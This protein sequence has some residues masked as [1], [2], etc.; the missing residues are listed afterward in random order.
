[1]TN[2]AQHIASKTA[3]E[4]KVQLKGAFQGNY[5]V[6]VLCCDNGKSETLIFTD[7]QDPFY[8]KNNDILELIK[9]TLSKPNND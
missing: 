3:Q 9:E 7:S 1:M 4:F 5:R 2:K 8:I 6:L